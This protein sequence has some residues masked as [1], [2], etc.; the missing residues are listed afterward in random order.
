MK[1]IKNKYEF[2]PFVKERKIHQTSF[3]NFN[4]KEEVDE[5]SFAMNSAIEIGEGFS[6]SIQASCGHYCTPR[7]TLKNLSD[8]EQFEILIIHNDDYIV[9][10]K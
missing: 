1:N 3:S 6:L 5:N 8:Y 7:K 2:I 9:V 4:N 10:V